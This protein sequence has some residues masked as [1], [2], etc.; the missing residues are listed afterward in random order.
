[1]DVNDACS[2]VRVFGVT[3]ALLSLVDS[4]VCSLDVKSL[5]RCAC[6]GMLDSYQSA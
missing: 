2:A 3:N 1:M 4:V 5:S 6:V